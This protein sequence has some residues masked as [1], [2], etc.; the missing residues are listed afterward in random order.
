MA[1]RLF[2]YQYWKELENPSQRNREWTQRLPQ[3]ITALNNEE[4]RVIGMKPKEAIKKKEVEHK[5]PV[6][7]SRAVF[8]KEKKLG[9][10]TVRHLYQ[11]GELEGGSKRATDPNW[12]LK[13]YQIQSSI[14][15]K[16]QPILYYLHGGPKRGFV[17]EE[18]LI[19]PEG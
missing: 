17:K 12:S 7:S 18:L 16:G 2:G 3:V 11:P 13:T 5:S 8:P 4:A 9:N 19:V 14:S 1:E 15:K 10:V 6:R